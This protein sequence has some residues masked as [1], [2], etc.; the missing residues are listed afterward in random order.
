M[1]ST[2]EVM[3]VGKSFAEAFGK[4]TLAAGFPLP[5][6][7]CAFLSVKNS[8][9]PALVPIAQEL[10]T[11]GFELVASRGTADFLSARG[12]AGEGGK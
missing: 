3:G 2:G 12:V 4:A 7:G 6:E 1:R 11:L 5:L 8:D 9:K 10:K